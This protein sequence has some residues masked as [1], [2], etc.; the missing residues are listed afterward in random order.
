MGQPSIDRSELAPG[1]RS[2]HIRHSLQES[3]AQPVAR[4][5]HVIFYR[6]GVGRSLEIVRVLHER[7]EPRRH[8]DPDE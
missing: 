7:M 8:V 3:S 6:L 2:F 4:P 1:L 5:V